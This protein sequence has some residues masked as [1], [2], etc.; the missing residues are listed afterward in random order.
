MHAFLFTD[1]LPKFGERRQATSGRNF[2]T[3][4]LLECRELD[5]NLSGREK[6]DLQNQIKDK[7]TTWQN[8]GK[9]EK[10]SVYYRDL[11]NG[12]WFGIKEDDKF[13]PGSLLKLP[14]AMSFF[15]QSEYDPDLLKKQIEYDKGSSDLESAQA[16]SEFK[17]LEDKKVYSVSDL[18]TIMLTE[19]SNEAA[20]VLAQLAGKDQLGQVYDDFGIDEP[21]AG[22]DY[23]T[24]VHSYSSFFRILYNATYLDRVDSENLLKLLT[25]T[26]FKDGLVA[27]V[28]LS[29]PVAHKFGSRAIA[30]EQVKQLHDCGI[31]Y[32]PKNPYTLCI[33]TQGA[34]YNDLAA[35]IK[36]ISAIVYR[37]AS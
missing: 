31:V 29:V 18:I 33:M 7:I 8:E 23:S 27:G 26:K 16:F 35:A 4:P 19:S 25:T 21:V 1:Q 3:N 30:G 15:A 13:N 34:N 36:E 2:F 11:N 22:Q 14:L 10:A 37:A 9:I 28:P 20:L 12:P 24:D 5:E 6:K 17:G 32:V